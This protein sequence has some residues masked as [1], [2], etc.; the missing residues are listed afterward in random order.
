MGQ[1]SC[2][3]SIGILVMLFCAFFLFYGCGNSSGDDENYTSGDDENYTSLQGRVV[4]GYVRD[5]TVEVYSS[6]QGDSLESVKLIAAGTTDENGRFSI[7][8]P[9]EDLP[10]N[11]AFVSRGGTVIDTGMP[12]PTMILVPI[13]SSDDPIAAVDGDSSGG[14]NI[15]PVTDLFLRSMMRADDFFEWDDFIDDAGLSTLPEVF[16]DP[17][18]E[19]A[20]EELE[21]ALYKCLASGEQGVVLADG[22]YRMALVYLDKSHTGDA[23]PD[24]SS[25]DGILNN[26]YLEATLSIS[27]G[28]V[29]GTLFDDEGSPDITGRIQGANLLLQIKDDETSVTNISGTLGLLGSFSGNYADFDQ[30]AEP[31]LS[32]GVFVASLMPEEGMDIDGFLNMAEKIYAGKRNALFR[33]IYGDRD[34]GWGIVDN[35]EI[36][37][38]EKEISAD[39]FKISLNA[40]N[41]ESGLIRFDQGKLLELGLDDGTPSGLAVLRFKETEGKNGSET[42]ETDYAYLI[43]AL[44][45]RRG[46]YIA[47]DSETGS[48]YA[49]GE[50]YFARN[51]AVG[52]HLK[53]GETYS[54]D[55][56]V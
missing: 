40:A 39:D 4:D 26:N 50:S 36:D 31:P 49:V 52:G 53:A 5:A 19:G 27:G 15:T 3:Y 33:D 28:E 12:A 7:R 29:S 23:G 24:F 38:G 10:E 35:L 48:A 1:R 20:S 25:I 45:N 51:D 13:Y 41:E 34:L 6:V 30:G 14:Y 44:G 18:A 42:D 32:T 9:E 21:Q 43:Q 2:F 55:L 54:Y 17:L 46:I 8:L 37:I 16:E 47:G 11:M 56:Y 22:D